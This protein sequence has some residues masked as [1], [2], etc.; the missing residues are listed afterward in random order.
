MPYL[1]SQ[2]RL[3]IKRF[4]MAAVLEPKNPKQMPRFEM[5]GFGIENLSIAF[6]GCDELPAPLG[7]LCA[8]EHSL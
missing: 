3:S 8:A 7:G 2:V 6:L 1:C 5:T 4:T